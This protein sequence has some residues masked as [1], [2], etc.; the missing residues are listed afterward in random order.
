MNNTISKNKSFYFFIALLAIA[1]NVK[2]NDS[3]AIIPKPI[4]MQVHDGHFVLNNSTA[5][6]TAS[7]ETDVNQSIQWFI[8]KIATST[9][10]HLL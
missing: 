2:A 8:D 10:Y 4:S 6:S 9:G 1:F 5:I 7:S 3:I